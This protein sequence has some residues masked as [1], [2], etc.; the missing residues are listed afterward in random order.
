[1]TP[2]RRT[3]ATVEPAACGDCD[4]QGQALT[5]MV[6]GRGLRRRTVEQYAV[7]LTCDG[8]GLAPNGGATA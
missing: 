7:C 1:M 8:T 6:I 3:R 5:A 4:G 2:A